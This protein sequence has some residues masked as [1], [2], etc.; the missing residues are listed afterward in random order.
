MRDIFVLPKAV[1]SVSWLAPPELPVL[2]N[3]EVHVWRASLE[4]RPYQ[5]KTLER[6]LSDDESDRAGRF[7]FQKGR[8]YFIAARGILRTILGRYLKMNPA[9]L[10]FSYGPYGKP[11]LDKKTNPEIIRFNI[12]HSRG[13]ALYAVTQKRE[14]GVDLEYINSGSS[15]GS[16]AEQYFSQ[17]E[18]AALKAFPEH[19]R[20]QLFFQLWTRKEACLKAQGRGLSGDLKQVNV[21]GCTGG[22]PEASGPSQEE[23]LWALLDLAVLP[24]YASALV[25]EGNDLQFKFWQQEN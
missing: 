1:G 21:T 16:I 15:F 22:F 23:S 17:R 11:E 13:L 2:N 4:M 7:H 25:V 9:N 6:L 19:L 20:Q 18:A 3:K 24:E 12:S 8:D 10:K 14:I 5:L